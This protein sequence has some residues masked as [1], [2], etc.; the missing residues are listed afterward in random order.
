MSLWDYTTKASRFWTPCQAVEETDVLEIAET[1]SSGS[2]DRVEHTCAYLSALT[3]KSPLVLLLGAS[4]T[5]LGQE[6][7]LKKMAF[8]SS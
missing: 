6:L 1:H 3:S 8:S 5:L 7:I 2:S 4:V